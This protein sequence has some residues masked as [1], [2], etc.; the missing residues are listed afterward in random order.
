[1]KP[2]KV[3][4]LARQFPGAI[5]VPV[6]AD[7]AS[8]HNKLPMAYATM[9]ADGTGL[10]FDDGIVQS[11]RAHHTGAK[12]LG[13]FM[14]RAQFDGE[15]GRGA[16]YILVDDH[17]TQGGTIS[18]LLHFIE[19][20]GGKVVA[21]TTLTAS[22]GSTILPIREAT[23]EKLL[24]EYAA[25]GKALQTD[26]GRDRGSPSGSSRVSRGSS[27]TLARAERELNEFLRR[28]DIAGNV[29][30]LTESEAQYILQFTPEHFKG[31][32]EL[33]ATKRA[34]RSFLVPL[35]TRTRGLGRLL[36]NSVQQR[37]L[38]TRFWLS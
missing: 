33:S 10:K 37:T 5:V 14:V 11:V 6:H 28:A 19:N 32:I 24:T 38:G 21:V 9:L 35:K 29:H 1:M 30:A 18:E 7:E 8:G 25:K 26:A 20:K 16:K 27:Q 23:L 12:A 17:I 4:Q 31:E 2:E 13:R 15:V 3:K 36:T 34:R 22:K